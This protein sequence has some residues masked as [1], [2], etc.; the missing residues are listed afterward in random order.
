LKQP[1]SAL[2]ILN[3]AMRVAEVRGYQHTYKKHIAARL[4]C[5]M[6][7]INHR[8]GTMVALRTAIVKTAILEENYKIMAQ[9]LA[10]EHPLMRL[11]SP[12]VRYKVAKHLAA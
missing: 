5:T 12:R 1:I 7:M 4:D 2:R 10:A 9:A 6:G 3:A 8:W 11:V